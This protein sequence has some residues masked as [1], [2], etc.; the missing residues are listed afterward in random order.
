M[1]VLSAKQ[2][3]V[4]RVS[5]AVPYDISVHA[6]ATSS[7]YSDEEHSTKC[8]IDRGVVGSVHAQNNVSGSSSGSSTS[9][10]R[11]HGGWRSA[12]N[13][14]TAFIELD[15]QEMFRV[16]FILIQWDGCGRG[17]TRYTVQGATTNNPA[18]FNIKEVHESVPASSADFGFVKNIHVHPPKQMRFVR[19]DM[20]ERTG[21]ASN[22]QCTQYGIR[23]IQVYGSRPGKCSEAECVQEQIALS[24]ALKATHGL[25]AD[26]PY[27]MLGGYAGG[28]TGSVDLYA[29]SHASVVHI[30]PSTNK[31]DFAGS[32]SVWGTTSNLFKPSALA[33]DSSA[34][35]NGPRKLLVAN[36]DSPTG[37]GRGSLVS[38]DLPNPSGGKGTVLVQTA[39][40]HGVT[41]LALNGQGF[42]Y[43]ATAMGQIMKVAL[44]NGAKVSV[45]AGVFRTPASLI[46]LPPPN[47]GKTEKQD[48]LALTAGSR[49]T[50]LLRVQAVPVEAAQLPHEPEFATFA[51]AEGLAAAAAAAAAS[52]LGTQIHAVNVSP[53]ATTR[54][55]LNRHA[56]F[57]QNSHHKQG[58]CG[59]S[60]HAQA[61]TEHG[62]EAAFRLARGGS[63]NRNILGT[64]ES[65]AAL[66]LVA[67]DA[68]TVAAEAFHDDGV[69]ANN[70]KWFAGAEKTSLMY[71]AA[72]SVVGRSITQVHWGLRNGKT[73]QDSGDCPVEIY[74]FLLTLAP[75]PTERDKQKP[76]QVTLRVNVGAGSSTNSSIPDGYAM[77][78]SANQHTP[79]THA[80]PITIVGMQVRVV[81]RPGMSGWRTAGP[82]SFA[83]MATSMKIMS[84]LSVAA[85]V[86]TSSA[87]AVFIATGDV[88]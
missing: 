13:A 58:K 52:K 48:L 49:P 60:A 10:V 88:R 71:K 87:A 75:A 77:L 29:L 25:A 59:P 80:A 2:H 12:A 51:S 69:A 38:F 55:R 64:A 65:N 9:A 30:S 53:G 28:R 56:G 74:E 70:G 11:C 34:D 81:A 19:L 57:L 83:Q 43:A 7:G 44:Q 63:L 3:S 78:L 6:K 42:A 31:D 5:P 45:V 22:P 26:P 20:Q 61:E 47:T 17:A 33:I 14:P 15:L 32:V 67:A 35:G 41:S 40:L 66:E 36:A 16:N 37:D 50:S 23:K 39:E 54:I 62:L 46:C 4:V 82:G 8:L 68:V 24:P 79:H 27:D 72:V 18:L 86:S 85:A 73:G 84:P 76:F 1:Y 21:D